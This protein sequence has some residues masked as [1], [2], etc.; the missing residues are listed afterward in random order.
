MSALILTPD[1][2]SPITVE[3]T[4]DGGFR[5]DY[6]DTQIIERRFD[7]TAASLTING[8]A[9]SR[10]RHPC[11]TAELTS[12]ERTSLESTLE[13][14]GTVTASGDLLDSAIVCR[15]E[16]I[17]WSAGEVADEEFLTFTLVEVGS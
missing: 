7:G 17:G 4:Q 10:T 11:V 16:D 3:V 13:A 5:T 2:G 15:V 14:I 1:G 9:T 8:T 12:A 6:D